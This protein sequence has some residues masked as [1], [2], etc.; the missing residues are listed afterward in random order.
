MI[1]A[2]LACGATTCHVQV[3]VLVA[4]ATRRGSQVLDSGDSTDPPEDLLEI[5]RREVVFAE[6]AVD[7][8]LEVVEV[9]VVDVG[10]RHRPQDF[11][12]AGDLL[13]ATTPT[14]STEGPLDGVVDAVDFV[15]GVVLEVND[16]NV[17]G[18]VGHGEL[19]G[20]VGSCSRGM[21]LTYYRH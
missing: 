12:T 17:V 20:V 14:E 2:V 3:A 1:A 21:Y 5:G 6:L 15:V 9:V 7:G 8:L 18:E 19:L 13:T 4:P 11:G 10:S 16:D